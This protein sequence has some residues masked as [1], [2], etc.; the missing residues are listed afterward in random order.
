MKKLTLLTLLTFVG[1]SF[2]GTVS[3]PE[4]LIDLDDPVGWQFACSS[5]LSTTYFQWLSGAGLIGEITIGRGESVGMNDDELLEY[6]DGDK[7][8]LLAELYKDLIA[9]I[10][11]ISGSYDLVFGDYSKVGS[12]PT[13]F[14]SVDY[15]DNYDGIDYYNLDTVFIYDGQYFFIVAYCARKEEAILYDV[16]VDLLDSVSSIRYDEEAAEQRAAEAGWQAWEAEEEERVAEEEARLEERRQ[17]AAQCLFLHERTRR[18]FIYIE[19]STHHDDADDFWES[20]KPPSGGGLP[21]SSYA[22]TRDSYIHRYIIIHKANVFKSDTLTLA[23]S[24][25]ECCSTEAVHGYWDDSSSVDWNYWEALRKIEDEYGSD[26][27]LKLFIQDKLNG[28]FAE[29]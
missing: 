20:I 4:Y 1:L 22:D 3:V 27:A 9:D 21:S 16:A 14:A 28:Y 15:Y 18:D 23:L 5:D 12:D 6:N 17:E 25:W 19:G 8:I 13:Y 2:A 7:E 10:E 11:E 29:R 26:F 24:R